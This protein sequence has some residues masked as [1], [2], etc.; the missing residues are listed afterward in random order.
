MTQA[1]LF[2]VK[3]PEPGKVKT[4]L[5]RDIGDENAAQL[6]ELFIRDLAIKIKKLPVDTIVCFDPPEFEEEFRRLICGFPVY[7]PQRGSGLGMRLISCFQGAFDLGFTRVNVIG[8][9]SPDLSP[10]II[11]EAFDA[12]GRNGFCIGP[13]LDGGYYL[14]GFS[15]HIFQKE[16]FEKIPWSTDRVF[17][18]TLTLVSDFGLKSHLLPYWSDVD[19]FPDLQSLYNQNLF[20]EFNSSGTMRWL[21]EYFKSQATLV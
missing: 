16:F 13:T 21:R 5:A 7:L 12:L 15:S 18:R 2:F 20:T 3:Y 10:E 4:R 9:D 1:L 14:I 19:S 11:M 17:E 8:S 6:Y